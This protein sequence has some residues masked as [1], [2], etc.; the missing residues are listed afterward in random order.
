[1][2]MPQNIQLQWQNF[3]KFTSNM[4]T[5]FFPNSNV[6]INYNF[7]RTETLIKVARKL[8]G[9]WWKCLKSPEN[10]YFLTPS[11]IYFCQFWLNGQSYFL[12]VPKQKLCYFHC[13]TG[14]LWFCSRIRRIHFISTKKNWPVVITIWQQKASKTVVENFTLAICEK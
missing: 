12:Q 4:P 6:I 9:H 13:D 8:T 10:K 11:W 2:E 1:M 5:M 3:Q 7:K 14:Y